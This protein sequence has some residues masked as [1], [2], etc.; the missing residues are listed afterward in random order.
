MVDIWRKRAG[1]EPAQD[2]SATPT[3]FEVRPTH[4]GRFSSAGDIR[5]I[6]LVWEAEQEMRLPHQVRG[7]GSPARAVRR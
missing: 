1:V 7:S 3:G 4:R 2:R 6:N 5:P